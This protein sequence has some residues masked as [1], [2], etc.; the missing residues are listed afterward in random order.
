MEWFWYFVIY[1]TL[2]FCLEVAFARITGQKG[3]RKAA[4]LLPLCPVYGLGAAAVLLISK[5]AGN[6]ILMLFMAGGAVATVVEYAVGVWYEREL[7]VSFWDYDGLPGNVQGRVCLPFSV[8]WGVLAVV[9]VRIVHPVVEGWM[10]DIPVP[11]TIAAA[12]L[13][14]ADLTVSGIMMKY[15]G[16]RD[17]LRW[18]K[19]TA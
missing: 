17:C 12:V 11:V 19:R 18:Y 4:L 13:T 14:A 10:V 9:L 7:G 8:V 3:A 16:G 15:T 6:N 1:S 5:W 2:G